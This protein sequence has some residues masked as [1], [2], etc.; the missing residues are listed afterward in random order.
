MEKFKIL[1]VDDDQDIT[2]V[3]EKKLIKDGFNV[4]TVSTGSDAINTARTFLPNLILM[5]I[6]LPDLDG[7]EAVRQLKEIPETISIPIVFLSGIVTG[8]HGEEHSPEVK[9]AGRTFR[10]IGKPFS[11]M[12]LRE[13]IDEILP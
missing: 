8:N 13:V 5:D 6:V 9:V 10:A 1:V 7:S 2:E 3:L 12:H 11:Y 4:K